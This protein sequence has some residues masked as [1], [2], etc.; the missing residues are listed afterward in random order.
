MLRESWYVATREIR[1]FYRQRIQVITALVTPLIWLALFGSALSG[2]LPGFNLSSLGIRGIPTTLTFI[3]FS[4]NLD[5]LMSA[6]PVWWIWIIKYYLLNLTTISY[7]SF[8]SPGI[9]AMTAMFTAMF[10]G[11][12]IVWDRRFGFL[13][14]LLVSPIPRSSIML[15]KMISATI[16]AMTQGLIVIALAI[17]VGAKINTG[18]LGIIMAV[19]YMA[20]FSLGFSGMSTAVGIKMAEHEEFFGVINLI[21]MPLFFASGALFPVA[22][23]PGWLQ[24]VAYGNP[25][26]YA[27]DGIRGCLIGGTFGLLQGDYAFIGVGGS[28]LVDAAVLGL[29]IV[30]MVTIGVTVFRRSL[31]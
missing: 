27:V 25:L 30:I 23:M 22:L 2:G 10:A 4:L 6:V 8:L 7:I 31:K 29:F 21:L 24:V 12:S 9:V 20:L 13:N 19:P 11:V 16:R 3:V 18:L 14:K 1:H 26:T 5:P 28:L 17:L 15:G